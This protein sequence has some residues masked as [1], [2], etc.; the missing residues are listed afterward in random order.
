MNLCKVLIKS[1]LL[2]LC[3]EVLLC[4]ELNILEVISLITA[5]AS[6]PEQQHF[7]G[8]VYVETDHT[9]TLVLE[10]GSI[11]C[12]PLDIIMQYKTGLLQMYLYN[13]VQYSSNFNLLI[14]LVAC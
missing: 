2:A 11:V 10:G 14:I 7:N 6:E 3:D 5:Q 8:S 13:I 12:F 1:T 9:L 4:D